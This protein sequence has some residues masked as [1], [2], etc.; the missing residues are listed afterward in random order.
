M[1]KLLTEIEMINILE[2][3]T[4]KEQTK[5]H[6][7]QIMRFA[8]GDD[9][10]ASNDKGEKKVYEEAKGILNNIDAHRNQKDIN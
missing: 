4:I 10:I 6:Q 1:K 8:F 5:L 3:K 7:S 9:F 2:N